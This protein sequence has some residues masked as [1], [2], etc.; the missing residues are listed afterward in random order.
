MC[1]FATTKRPYTAKRDLTCYKAIRID[2]SSYTRRFWFKY[3]KDELNVTKMAIAKEKQFADSLSQKYGSRTETTIGA[4]FH[5]AKRPQRFLH[6]LANYA[7]CNAIIC[8]FIIPKGSKYYLDDTG[9]VVSNQIILKETIFDIEDMNNMYHL[10]ER[11]KPFS[12]RDRNGKLHY[13]DPL[14][15]DMNKFKRW[16]Q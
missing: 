7:C 9:L 15:D 2:G 11:E 6:A 12:I 3:K 10:V 4:G 1:L 13:V 14:E 8:R 16:E 5:S